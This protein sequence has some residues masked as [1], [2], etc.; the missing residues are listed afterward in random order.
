MTY[1]E[2]CRKLET[3]GCRFQRQADADPT[4]SG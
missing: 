1:R 4:K 3:L 2:L